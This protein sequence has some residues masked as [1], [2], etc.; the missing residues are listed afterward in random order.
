MSSNDAEFLRIIQLH[1]RAWG[2]EN[3]SGKPDLVAFLNAKVVVLW[4]IPNKDRWQATLHNNL[5]EIEAELTKSLMRL[6]ISP[7]KR[8]IA[9]IFVN[10]R[11]VCITGLKVKFEYCDLLDR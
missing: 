2:N 5:R 11:E 10:K 4:Q 3:Y 6:S 8:T 1:E 9:K 7:P